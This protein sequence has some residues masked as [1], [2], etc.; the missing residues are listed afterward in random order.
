M[1]ICQGAS[2]TPRSAWWRVR[3][4]AEKIPVFLT[5]SP[6]PTHPSSSTTVQCGMLILK[7][8]PC[9]VVTQYSSTSYDSVFSH[10]VCALMFR[11]CD[12]EH[13]RFVN[14]A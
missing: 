11:P 3:S 2:E 9:T 7:C 10:A 1:N 14:R 13:L 5:S 8:S 4:G 6:W 12:S